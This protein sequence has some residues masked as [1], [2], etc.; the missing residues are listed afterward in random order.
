[1]EVVND[2]FFNVLAQFKQHLANASFVALDL[3]L[4]GLRTDKSGKA[5]RYDLVS[6]RFDKTKLSVTS[7][8]PI[9][10]GLCLFETNP[11]NDAVTVRAFNFN[12]FQKPTHGIGDSPFFCQPSSLDF[13]RSNGFDFNRWI[14]K[15]NTVDSK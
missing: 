1:M 6:D 2:N 7:F 13:L 15:G 14:H 11:N 5:S 10:C 3:E 4:T 9:Q 12:L 8:I